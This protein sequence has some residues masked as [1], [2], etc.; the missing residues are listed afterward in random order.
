M[1]KKPSEHD[2]GYA[3]GIKQALSIIESQSIL[4]FDAADT[5]R[6]KAAIHKVCAQIKKK[7]NSELSALP[8]GGK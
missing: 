7:L 6:E 2:Q 8:N 5:L 1:S 4:T 3:L